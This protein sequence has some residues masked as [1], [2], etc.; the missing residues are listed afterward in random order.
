M[1]E[2]NFLINF[3]R[4]YDVECLIEITGLWHFLIV[5][6]IKEDKTGL[7]LSNDFT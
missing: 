7:A 3:P 6:H 1:Q 2:C 5:I 4:D